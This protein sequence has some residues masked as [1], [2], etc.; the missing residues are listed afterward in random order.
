MKRTSIR[1]VRESHTAP[2]NPKSPI[3]KI[4]I[5]MRIKINPE[6]SM[7]ENGKPVILNKCM[8]FCTSGRSKAKT[9]RTISAAPLN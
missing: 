7:D 8:A 5:P 2:Q 9:P 4:K 3:R 1:D 6:I